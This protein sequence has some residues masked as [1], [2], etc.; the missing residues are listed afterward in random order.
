M[1]PCTTHRAGALSGGEL[2]RPLL[3]TDPAGTACADVTAAYGSFNPGRRSHGCSAATGPEH[4]DIA[5]KAITTVARIHSPPPKFRPD[6]QA[7]SQLAIEFDLYAVCSSAR[8]SS[9]I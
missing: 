6:Y 4:I 9:L 1:I 5:P 8:P 7:Q 2:S 3:F